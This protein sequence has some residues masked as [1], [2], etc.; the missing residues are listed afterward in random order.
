[1]TGWFGC[2]VG[3]K[4]FRPY[5]SAHCPL[6]TVHFQFSILNFHLLYANF[7]YPF[8]SKGGNGLP[9]RFVYQIRVRQ[10]ESFCVL[11]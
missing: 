7:P 6:I 1:M 11:M 2:F 4:I 9:F 5:E 8:F 3:R 10:F